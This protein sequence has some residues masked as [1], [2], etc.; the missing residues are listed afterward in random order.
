[1]GLSDYGIASSQE[2]V[3]VATAADYQKVLDSRFKYLEVESEFDVN[4]ELPPLAVGRAIY[5]IPIFTHNLN[6][7]PA[8]E[9]SAVVTAGTMD[10][11]F[12]PTMLSNKTGI[13]IRRQESYNP[14]S[15][16]TFK[17]SV[18]IYNLAILESYQAAKDNPTLVAGPVSTYGVR[19]LDGTVP[20]LGPTDKSSVG[21]SIDTKKKIL[22]VHHTGLISINDYQFK[23]LK[24]TNIDVTTNI[25]TFINGD[26]TESMEWV[27]TGAAVSYSTR[28]PQPTPSITN[29]GSPLFTSVISYLIKL[30]ETTFKLATTLE[31]ALAGIEIDMLTSGTLPGDMGATYPGDTSTII[32]DVGYPP[33]YMIARVTMAWPDMYIGPIIN[34]LLAVVAATN[35]TLKFRGIQSS[36]SGRFGLIILKDP[37]EVA[38]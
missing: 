1:M 37:A 14:T 29:S 8:Y 16:Q 21:Y 18:R 22:A 28:N 2:G 9:S 17:G 27:Q 10:Y 15:A 4:I 25:F 3:P 33:T 36:F 38:G 13:F 34:Q 35:T 7:L 30:T 24:I 26:I 19:S 6:F 20:N 32:H 31:N 11:G 23:R 12:T 5:D